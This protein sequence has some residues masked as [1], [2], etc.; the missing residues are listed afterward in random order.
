MFEHRTERLLPW[1]AFA[2]R[3]VRHVL[4]SAAVVAVALCLGVVGYHTLERLSWIESLLNASMILGGMGPVDVL[5]TS[6]GKLFA[7][8]Y[9]LFS[10]VVFIAVAGVLLA[11]LLHRLIHHFHLEIEEESSAGASTSKTD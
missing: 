1:A 10:G 11:P 6:A 5:H 3:I 9:A 7:S 2:A 4:I 8:A